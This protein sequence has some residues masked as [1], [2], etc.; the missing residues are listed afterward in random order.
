[1]PAD[2]FLP[3]RLAA[4]SCKRARPRDRTGDQ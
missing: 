3:M 1:L 2:P 4:R